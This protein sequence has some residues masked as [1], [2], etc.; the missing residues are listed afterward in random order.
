VATTTGVVGA[1]GGVMRLWQRVGLGN[2]NAPGARVKRP[3]A[4][5]ATWATPRE[6]RPLRVRKPQP[7]RVILG[8]PSRAFGR[9][10][11]AEDCHSVLVF[12]PPGSFKTAG[13]VIP[14]ILEWTG[15]VLAT[16]VK[17]D[18]IKATRTHRERRGEVV[19]LDPLGASRLAGARWTPLAFCR[20]WAGAPSRWRPPSP[21]PQTSA[22]SHGRAQVLEDPGPETAGP[23]AV[24]GRPG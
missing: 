12:G 7:G 22:P 3:A 11:A 6:L 2:P 19:V 8:R 24:R 21:T 5:S 4:R 10:L 16:S 1:T 20:S 23:P 15:P 9:L 13:V 18:V 17:P 14:A